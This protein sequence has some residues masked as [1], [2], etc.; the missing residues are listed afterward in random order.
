MLNL[1]SRLSD[2]RFRFSNIVVA[3]MVRRRDFLDR[4]SG[5]GLDF[6]R[7]TTVHDA[8]YV[9]P[10]AKDRRFWAIQIPGVSS[11]FNFSV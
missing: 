8:W 4:V 9:T 7:S 3:P 5:F 6:Q 10:M 11:V 2:P 1:L